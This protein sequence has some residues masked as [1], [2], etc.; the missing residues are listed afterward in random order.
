MIQKINKGGF[1]YFQFDTVY[2]CFIAF[3]LSALLNQLPTEFK[4]ICLTQ[5]N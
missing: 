1:I 4:N 5:L 2:Y 3:S